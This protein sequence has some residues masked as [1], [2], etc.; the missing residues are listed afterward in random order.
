M[1]QFTTEDYLAFI[2]N[3]YKGVDSS[4]LATFLE[5]VSI[6]KS[7]N[8]GMDAYFQKLGI[9]HAR[10]KVMINLL[11]SEAEGGLSPAMLAEKLGVKRATVTGILDTLENDQWVERNPDPNDRRGLLI[12]ITEAGKAK[13]DSVLPTHYQR[14]GKA[15]ET[16]SA[17]EHEQLRVL[18]RKFG[19]GLD[20]MESSVCDM[21]PKKDSESGVERE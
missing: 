12:R 18:I 20:A 8:C 16:F 21:D 9:S 6:A 10:F 1:D 3:R 19:Q 4:A 2:T 17:T 11:Y 7:M 13:L 5:V 15:L 14:I